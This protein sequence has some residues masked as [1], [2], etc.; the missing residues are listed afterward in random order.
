MPEQSV[1][2]QQVMAYI[3]LALCGAGGIG[4]TVWAFV[5][6][7]LSGYTDVK[8]KELE[9]RLEE[10][11]QKFQ[12]DLEAGRQKREAEKQR[13]EAEIETARAETEA[14][15]QKLLAD[16]EAS[17]DSR[18]HQ[19]RQTELAAAYQQSESS[20]AQQQ[21][22]ALLEQAQA[23][24]QQRVAKN[25]DE[26]KEVLTQM[27]N[28]GIGQAKELGDLDRYLKKLDHELR[29]LRA[30]FRIL[31]TIVEEVYDHYKKRRLEYEDRQPLI[32]QNR[33][34]GDNGE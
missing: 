15:R 24:I 8:I 34:E 22:A 32:S 7:Y 19:Q 2:W 25:L 31:L 4:A 10:E 6:R 27:D 20:V 29:N 12:D 30:D 33:T 26:L 11:R 5:K 13:L 14:Q 23:F 28:R 18:E 3:V 9:V 17:K 21:M 16:L 1:T